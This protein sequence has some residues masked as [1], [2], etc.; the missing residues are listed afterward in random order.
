MT[1]PHV[2]LFLAG[3]IAVLAACGST[4]EPSAAPAS[5]APNGTGPPTPAV[6]TP[7][8]PAASPSATDGSP[9]PTPAP[10]PSPTPTPVPT[11][12]PKPTA[13]PPLSEFPQTW[14]GSWVDPVTGGSGSLDLVLTGKGT[15]FGGSITMDGTACLAGGV[16]D[17]SYDGRDID[18][19]VSQR[20]VVIRFRGR[21]S[22]STISGTF[23]TA[24]DGMDGTWTVQRLS[25]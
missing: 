4:V 25:R 15:G 17:G 2:T 19:R 8:S 1:K 13:A 18:F 24:C 3:L 16:L 6:S 9:A 12:T 7:P 23:S 11:P 10:T 22:A 14:T 5:P 21:A 20:E